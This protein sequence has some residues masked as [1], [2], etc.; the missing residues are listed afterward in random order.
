MHDILST[1]L[2]GFRF[3]Y[4]TLAEVSYGDNTAYT[5]MLHSLFIANMEP[6]RKLLH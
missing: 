4:E 1:V 2:Q 3:T 6:H 5:G